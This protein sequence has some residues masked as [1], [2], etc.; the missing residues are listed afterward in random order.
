VQ[1]TGGPSDDEKEILA[2]LNAGDVILLPEEPS[3]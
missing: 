3:S 1:I 2:G